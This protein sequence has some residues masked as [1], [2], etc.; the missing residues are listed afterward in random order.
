MTFIEALNNE[1]TRSLIEQIEELEDTTCER[2][3]EIR[4]SLIADLAKFNYT[5]ILEA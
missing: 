5:Y 4:T 2:L 1:E 3:V